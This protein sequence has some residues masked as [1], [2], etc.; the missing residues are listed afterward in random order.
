MLL[1]NKTQTSNGA[2]VFLGNVGLKGDAKEEKEKE[3][4]LSLWE[5]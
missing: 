3:K 5:G 1:R 2:F 4:G